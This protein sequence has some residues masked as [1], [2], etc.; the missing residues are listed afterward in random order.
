MAV[1]IT[2]KCRDLDHKIAALDDLAGAVLALMQSPMPDDGYAQLFQAFDANVC[3]CQV[4]AMLTI[5]AN[6][7]AFGVD[8]TQRW[9]SQIRGMKTAVTNTDARR[10]Q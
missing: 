5:L 7:Y 3:S 9:L 1:T 8:P 10:R 6:E 4:N 2:K